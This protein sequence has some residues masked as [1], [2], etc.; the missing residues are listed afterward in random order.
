M[1]EE[2][3]KKEDLENLTYKELVRVM[4]HRIESLDERERLLQKDLSRIHGLLEGK[5]EE[6]ERKKER[7][8]TRRW[9][10]ATVI[11]IIGLVFSIIVAIVNSL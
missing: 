10:V 11:S 8:K 9:Q 1:S 2:K 5:K 3:E 6:E 7:S 4:I